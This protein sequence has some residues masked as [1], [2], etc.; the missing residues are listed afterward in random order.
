MGLP[1]KESNSARELA[2]VLYDFL[3][4]SGSEKWRGHV[5]FRTIAEEVGVGDF[6]K[7]GS[8]EPMIAQLLE[9]TLQF[10][11]SRFEPLVVEIVRAGLTYRRTNG[12]PVTPEDVERINAI[13]LEIGFKV[14]RPMGCRFPS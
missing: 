4:G 8:K 7:Q 14:P 3:P 2:K 5:S 1:L 9:H 10:R 11:R 12:R 6:W 13:L